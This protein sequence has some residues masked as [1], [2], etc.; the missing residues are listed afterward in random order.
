MASAQAS[1]RR[2]SIPTA[3]IRTIF[4]AAGLQK[5]RHGI[6]PRL[7]QVGMILR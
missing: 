5:M 4:T 6:R 1:E 7:F 3:V 2:C